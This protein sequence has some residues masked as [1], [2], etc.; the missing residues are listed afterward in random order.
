MGDAVSREAYTSIEEL[1]LPRALYF[2]YHPIFIS[3]SICTFVQHYVDN[4]PV[5][6][7]NKIL[8]FIVKDIKGNLNTWIDTPYLRIGWC[9]TIKTL[10]SPKFIY[11]LIDS[12][13]NIQAEFFYTLMYRL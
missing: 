5:V 7:F 13:A 1:G 11:K 3:H 4:K 8:D 12:T 2:K 10:V 9:S 6:S